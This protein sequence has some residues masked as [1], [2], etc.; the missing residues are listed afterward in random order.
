MMDGTSIATNTLLVPNIPSSFFTYQ[1]AL[2]A[3]KDCFQQ[4]GTI[5]V[6]VAMKGFARLMIIYEETKCA[7]E[8]KRKLDKTSL[9]WTTTSQQDGCETVHVTSI[10][11]MT[12]DTID[13]NGQTMELRVYFGQHN[14]INPDLSQLQLQVPESEKNFLISPPGSPCEGWQQTAESPPNTAVLAS[15]LTHAVDALSDD[16]MDL[17]NFS[18]E[19]TDEKRE[20]RVLKIISHHEGSDDQENDIPSIT[21]QDWDGNDAKTQP[22]PPRNFRPPQ[23]T[24]VPTSRPPVPT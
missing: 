21:V 6:F 24:M 10:G 19:P 2:E 3:I 7:M 22:K 1:A 20:K 17:D 13:K 9:C 4:F 14:P 11:G 15:D 12:T 23:A 18:L 16:D 8:A 5:Y